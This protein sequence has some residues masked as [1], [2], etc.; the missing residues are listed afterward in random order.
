MEVMELAQAR[1][2]DSGRGRVVV[3]LY[4]SL[5]AHAQLSTNTVEVSTMLLMQWPHDGQL[6]KR[7]VLIEGLLSRG[8]SES[9]SARV[10]QWLAKN[11]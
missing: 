3:D 10:Q 5:L 7:R 8:L 11:Q 4:T 6:E 9:L 2:L 1:L